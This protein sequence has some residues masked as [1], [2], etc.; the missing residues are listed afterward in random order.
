MPSLALDTY[1]FNFNIHYEC[2]SVLRNIGIL[3]PQALVS[4]QP[5][6]GADFSI[7]IKRRRVLGVPIPQ[8]NFDLDGFTPFSPGAVEHA[9]AILEWGMNYCVARHIMTFHTFHAATVANKHGGVI[10]SGDSGSGKSTLSCAMMGSGWRLLTDELTLYDATS[11]TITPFV[12]P[13]S[14]KETAI[15]VLKKEF[16]DLV[17]GQVAH[18]TTKGTVT[19]VRAT[20]SSWQGRTEPTPLSC[21][22]F[23]KYNAQCAAIQVQRL[24]QAQTIQQL[25]DQSFNLHTLGSNAVAGLVKIARTVPAYHIEYATLS[26]AIATVSELQHA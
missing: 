17:F 21:I 9:A 26:E 3:Y 22:I 12:R 25:S 4:E 7:A 23:P 16:P 13:V 6:H 5:L 2:E 10:L 18:N 11:N 1:P 14:I 19:H 24:S 8:V 15:A 20:D